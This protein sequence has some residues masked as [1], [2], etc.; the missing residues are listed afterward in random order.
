[1]IGLDLDDLA[2]DGCIT[3][4]PCGGEVAGRSPVDRGK[5]GMKRSV[6]CDGGGIPLHLVA[7]RAN[8]HDSPLLEPTLAGIPDMIEPRCLLP[9]GPTVHLDRGYDS[10]KT[11]DLL[12]PRLPGR[13]RGQGQPAPIQAGKRSRSS[14]STRVACDDCRKELR[15]TG[16]SSRVGRVLHRHSTQTGELLETVYQ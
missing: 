9:E 15:R 5:Q 8:E 2:V 14:G 4:A 11:R 16:G 3:K 6:A 1:M 12:D 7:A 10:G 13:D